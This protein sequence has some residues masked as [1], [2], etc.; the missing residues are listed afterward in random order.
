MKRFMLFVSTGLV[1]LVSRSANATN[2][3][4]SV[5][6]DLSNDR[7]NPT[8]IVLT[9]GSNTI[10][11]TQVNSN[12]TSG[13][14]DYYW[15]TI[16]AGSKLTNI[17]VVST[18]TTSL[19]FIGVQRGTT[20]TEPNQ[21]TNVANLLGYTHFGP[22]NATVG[23]DILGNLGTGAGAMDFIPPLGAGD[24]T[25]W[26]QETSTT[27]T[28]STLT[29]VVSAPPASVPVPRSA[30]AILGAGLLV[31]GCSLLGRR[32]TRLRSSRP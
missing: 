20:F 6:G 23:T 11:S 5:N 9:P 30:A 15:L 24:Y 22:A 16:P 2:Y 29:F 4:E 28:T 25:F 10:T 19:A 12:S 32:R 31:A 21:G 7:L 3:S 8:H 13:D 27:P 17:D 14:I 18:T 26:Q 1:L